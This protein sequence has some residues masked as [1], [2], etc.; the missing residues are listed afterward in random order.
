MKLPA[1]EDATLPL[2][3]CEEALDEPAPQEA[4]QALTDLTHKRATHSPLLSLIFD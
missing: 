3:P 4:T 2:D 1:H